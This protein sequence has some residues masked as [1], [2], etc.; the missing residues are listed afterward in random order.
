V[1]P[2]C[3]PRHPRIYRLAR[4]IIVSQPTLPPSTSRSPAFH[5]RPVHPR[6]TLYTRRIHAP[7]CS[8]TPPPP[9]VPLH[10]RRARTSNHPPH[11]LRFAPNAQYRRRC[12]AALD[13]PASSASC[14]AEEEVLETHRISGCA[15]Q[16]KRFASITKTRTVGLLFVAGRTHAD[17]P[18]GVRPSN[19]L[20]R[21]PHRTPPSVPPSPLDP[22]SPPVAL[23]DRQIASTPLVVDIP[24]FH[25]ALTQSQHPS[26]FLIPPSSLIP[27]HPSHPQLHLPLAPRPASHLVP[28]RASIVETQST[29]PPLTSSNARWLAQAGRLPLFTTRED[30]SAPST[31]T[32]C[33]RARPGSFIDIPVSCSQGWTKARVEHGTK[34]LCS[35]ANTTRLD[36]PPSPP[37]LPPP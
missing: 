26:T 19:H 11:R 23:A 36:L 14:A 24:P 9:P 32:V 21:R 30:G 37:L 1:P 6:S 15:C 5:T 29:A 2:L 31:P 13:R 3:D 27:S 7:H 4:L 10:P 12:V 34:H 8:Y 33:G 35:R 16:E 22:P 25:S 20:H 28:Q 17:T 18:S